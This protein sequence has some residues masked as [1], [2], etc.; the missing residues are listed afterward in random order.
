VKAFRELR[1]YLVRLD[2]RMMYWRRVARSH[3]PDVLATIDGD[4]LLRLRAGARRRSPVLFYLKYFN[5]QGYMQEQ[6]ARALSVGLHRVWGLDV[7]D[8]GAGFGYFCHVCDYF[9]H[10]AKALDVPEVPLF[11]DVTNFFGIDKTHWRIRPYERLPD[12]GTKFD[13]IASVQLGFNG[14]AD[15]SPWGAAEWEF[16]LDDV[17]S[18][19]LK[20]G[21]R[22]FFELNYCQQYG[23]Y[24]SRDVDRLFARYG[25]RRRGGNRVIMRAPPPPARCVPRSRP[26]AAP[27]SDTRRGPFCCT[28]APETARE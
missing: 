26:V 19:H 5:Y 22:I 12:M 4:A 20:P 6:I 28:A 24:L 11:D 23:D 25:A 18:N 10:R 8:I 17:F 2:P 21:G 14:L 7:L 9:G 15:E 16:F 27:P 1:P 3:L 13:L